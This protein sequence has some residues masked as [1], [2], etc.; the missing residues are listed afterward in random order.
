MPAKPTTKR[1]AAPKR[2]R[3][4]AKPPPRDPI[5][6][7]ARADT[8]F[9]QWVRVHLAALGW[10]RTDLARALGLHEASV[11]AWFTH[12]EVKKENLAR[13]LSVFGEDDRLDVTTL[14]RWQL[15][16][17]GRVRFLV[18]TGALPAS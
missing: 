17:P 9:R 16:P 1:K 11:F 14:R 13:L 10:S 4:P 3:L 7:E 6:E 5:P 2:R 18:G 15:E 8:R 12:S